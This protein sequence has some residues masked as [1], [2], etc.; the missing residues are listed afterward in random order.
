MCD[1]NQFFFR[2]VGGNCMIAVFLQTALTCLYHELQISNITKNKLCI[3][4]AYQCIF[5]AKKSSLV[6]RWRY[7]VFKGTVHQHDK[8]YTKLFRFNQLLIGPRARF[9]FFCYVAQPFEVIAFP[10]S[11]SHCVNNFFETQAQI[12]RCL[13]LVLLEETYLEF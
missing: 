10:R 7:L 11:L 6:N 3:H 8:F 2:G 1:S 4:Y 12:F 9:I 13:I 5:K